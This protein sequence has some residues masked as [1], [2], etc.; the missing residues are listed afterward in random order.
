MRVVEFWEALLPL[1]IMV[2]HS[3]ELTVVGKEGEC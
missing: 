3:N 2:Q 1:E